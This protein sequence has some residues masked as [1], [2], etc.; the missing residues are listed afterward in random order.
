MVLKMPR[1]KR[2]GS[3]SFLSHKMKEMQPLLNND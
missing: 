2:D 1:K 3:N